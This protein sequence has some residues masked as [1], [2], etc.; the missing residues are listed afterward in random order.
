MKKLYTL[1]LLLFCIASFSQT[2]VSKKINSIEFNTE[3]DLKIFLPKGYQN[4]TLLKYPLAIVLDDDHLF[5][6]YVGNAKIY[7]KADLAPKQIVIGVSTDQGINKDVSTVDKT[8]GLSENG[9]KFYDFIKKEV[10][11]YAQAN[12]KT[13]PF[14][15]IAGEG[16]AANFVTHF[17]KEQKPIFNTYVAISPK[18]NQHSQR[19]LNS[20]N[21]PR[22]SEIDNQFHVYVSSNP[23]ESSARS[24]IYNDIKNWMTS[25][26]SENLHITFD[27]FAKASSKP[28]AVSAALPYSFT[29]AFDLYSRISKEEYESKIKDLEPLEAIKYLESK[30]LDIEYIYGTNLNVRFED[31]YAIEGIV[32][33][34]MDGDYLRVLGDFVMIKHP[35]SHLGEYYVGKFHELGRNYEQ[36]L[37]YYKEAYGKMELSDPNAEAF[38][39]N[40]LRIEKAAEA[41]KLE[42][43]API[44]DIPLEE[45][46][47][48]EE[49]DEEEEE[50]E[51]E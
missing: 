42:Q 30:Y 10:I 33:D 17:L 18:F 31:I 43:D 13:S 50:E 45:D 37:F 23:F 40:I 49:E 3:R 24:T 51:E 1:L 47:E 11:P 6:L 34:K 27:D 21:L 22:L 48:D 2:I 7:A 26:E 8:G 28:L 35:N 12:Y 20:F 5:D 25:Y 41:N 9:K 19:I 32:M 14:L 15:T 46:E 16:Y 38:Y 4:D 29:K 39:E 36:A 44:E